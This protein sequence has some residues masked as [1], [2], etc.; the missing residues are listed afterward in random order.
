MSHLALVVEDDR[1]LRLIYR[2]VLADQDFDVFEVADSATALALLETH[3]PQLV[4][5]DMLLPRVSGQVVLDYLNTAAHLAKT[6]V[7][8]VSS[9]LRYQELVLER[10]L[11]EFVL[12]PIRPSQIRDIAAHALNVPV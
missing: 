9:S 10:P 4:F 8:V 6:Y 1:P 3:T 2:R 12:K 5:L 7:V 11:R